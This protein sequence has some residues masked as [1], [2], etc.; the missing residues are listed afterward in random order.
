M[1]TA[2]SGQAQVAVLGLDAPGLDARRRRPPPAPRRPPGRRGGRRPLEAA[3]AH[4]ARVGVAAPVVDDRARHPARHGPR[5]VVPAVPSVPAA[6]AVR[7]GAPGSRPSTAA[8]PGPT[9]RAWRRRRPGD[10]RTGPRRLGSGAGARAAAPWRPPS[11]R[12]SPGAAA[13]SWST[14]TPTVAPSPSSSGSWTRCPGVLA[15]TR[16]AASGQLAERF[17]SV[18]RGLDSRLSVITGLPRPDRWIEVRGGS[19]E[20]LLDVARRAGRRRRR[21]RL[22]PRGGPR[23]RRRPPA[24]PQPDDAGGARGWPTRCW[25]SGQPTRS[26]CPG[27]PAG[28]S[29]CA[30]SSARRRVRVVVNRMRP[31]LGWSEQSDRRHGRRLRRGGT[32]A[33]PARRPCRGRPLAGHRADPA[34]GRRVAADPGGGGRGRW[35]TPSL[36]SGVVPDARRQ[37]AAVAAP[38]ARSRSDSGCPVLAG[39]D[40]LCSSWLTDLEVRAPLTSTS[41][42]PGTVRGWSCERVGPAGHRTGAHRRHGTLRRLGV[43]AGQPR[44]PRP[45][46]A[47]GARREAAH[48][49]HRGPAHHLDAP[50]ERPARHHADD[51]ADRLHLRAGDQLAARGAR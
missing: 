3:R 44:P 10:G 8:G 9:D 15:A 24:R 16:L 47:T 41:R 35:S 14:P 27:S 12:S 50:V 45:R 51:A 48:H 13:R 36:E 33:L 5:V 37:G 34:R 39:L 6:R 26:A 18:Q 11:P 2:A 21:H 7:A 31:S 32:A 29:R 40:N 4:A 49:H 28:W 30:R 19:V 25:S 22:L 20:H 1:A 23:P 43:R 42:P 17:A 46:G 38:T